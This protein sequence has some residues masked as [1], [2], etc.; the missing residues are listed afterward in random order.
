[1]RPVNPVLRLFRRLASDRPAGEQ[2]YEYQHKIPTNGRSREE[3]NAARRAMEARLLEEERDARTIENP[4][5]PNTS[6][7][8]VVTDPAYLLPGVAIVKRRTNGTSYKIE[9]HSDDVALD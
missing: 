4:A 3:T 2:P 5:F 9:P 1:M 8:P 6:T 7:C